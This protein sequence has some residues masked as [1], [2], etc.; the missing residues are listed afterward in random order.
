M[1]SPSGQPRS[2]TPRSVSTNVPHKG[3]SS[4]GN[5]QSQRGY[6]PSKSAHSAN[7]GTR[8]TPEQ[9]LRGFRQKT[10]KNPPMRNTSAGRIRKGR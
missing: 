1:R 8:S 7:H 6:G 2:G 4:A 3:G 5:V 10:A 9:N